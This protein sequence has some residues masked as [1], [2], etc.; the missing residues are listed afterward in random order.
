MVGQ[1]V[2]VVQ[3]K[4]G[5]VQLSMNVSVVRVEHA[6]TRDSSSH[7]GSCAVADWVVGLDVY[8]GCARDGP[9]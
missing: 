5:I 6:H 7:A 9:S 8:A 1:R 3:W 2:Q 4:G